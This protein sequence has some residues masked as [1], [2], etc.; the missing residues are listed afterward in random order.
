MIGE[1]WD[2]G[3]QLYAGLLDVKRLAGLFL[4]ERVRVLNDLPRRIFPLFHSKSF[5]FHSKFVK[6]CWAFF[7]IVFFGTVGVALSLCPNGPTNFCQQFS[8]EATIAVSNGYI[9]LHLYIWSFGF[10]T[11]SLTET[12][13]K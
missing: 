8:K 10:I 13:S 4:R 7:L 5:S 12:L 9:W 2:S 3:P 11:Y 1:K 6:R